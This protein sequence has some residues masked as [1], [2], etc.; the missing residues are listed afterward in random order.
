MGFTQQLQR[1]LYKSITHRVHVSRSLHTNHCLNHVKRSIDWAKNKSQKYR[2]LYVRKVMAQTDAEVA[3]ILE[4]L[5]IS[6]KQQGDIVR[7]L[8]ETAAPDV[9]IKK[10][11][12]EL[13]A[14]KKV[15]E[16][17]ELSLAPKD[18]GFDRAVLEE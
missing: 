13:K 1:V 4:P 12:N 8:K 10:A 2:I 6:V 11:V 14:R 16:D 15:L 18:V 17:K 9:D 7:S 3:A 5:R